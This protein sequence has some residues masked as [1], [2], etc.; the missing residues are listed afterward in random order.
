M[1]HASFRDG[2]ADFNH[3]S[4]MNDSCI[5]LMSVRVTSAQGFLMPRGYT[6]Q[7]F[8]KRP[9][10][11]FTVGSD[12]GFDM[13]GWTFRKF[14]G[15]LIVKP[16][17]KPIKAL[18]ASLHNTVLERGKAWRQKDLIQ[19]LNRQLRSWANYH[20][21]VCA[22]DAFSCADHILTEMLWDWAKRRHPKK[23]RKWIT[24]NYWHNKGLR[25]RVFQRK[26]QN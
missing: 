18:N 16:S 5:S 25:N 11:G 22:K 26:M 2:F 23:N 10:R 9:T 12:D 21:S 7:P 17:Q 19:V 6:F 8:T 1:V 14:K 24:A 20:Q 13:L 4:G 3:F 15:K